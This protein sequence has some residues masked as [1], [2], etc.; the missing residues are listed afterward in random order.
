M[1]REN[2]FIVKP[3]ETP[4]MG[5]IIRDQY[6]NIF[7]TRTNQFVGIPTRFIADAQKEAHRIANAY[8]G[9]KKI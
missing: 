9:V 7:D 6:Y 4:P 2:R 1:T 8:K 3:C 5:I